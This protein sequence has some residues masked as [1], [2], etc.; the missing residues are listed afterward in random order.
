MLKRSDSH[1][2]VREPVVNYVKGQDRSGRPDEKRD[3]ELKQGPT[4]RRSSNARQ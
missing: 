3:Y 4:R 1:E 2:N